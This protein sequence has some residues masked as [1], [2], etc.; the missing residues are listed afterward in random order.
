MLKISLQVNQKH[1]AV[2]GY[3]RNFIYN[4]KYCL[5]TLK[6]KSKKDVDD[7]IKAVRKILDKEFKLKQG[8]LRC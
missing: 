4:Y 5:Y 7:E 3:N 1:P 6:T 8:S 2:A